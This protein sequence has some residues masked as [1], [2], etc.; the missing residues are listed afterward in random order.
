MGYH[1]LLLKMGQSG[2]K[3]KAKFLSQPSPAHTHTHGETRLQTNTLTMT[4]LLLRVVHKKRMCE[5]DYNVLQIKSPLYLVLP[6]HVLIRGEDE[7][8]S[9]VI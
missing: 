7:I 9:T 5:I 6:L 3:S 1:F 4:V 8:I 2:I